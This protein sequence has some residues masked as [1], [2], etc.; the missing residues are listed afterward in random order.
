MVCM[1]ARQ[2]NAALS[3]M[4]NKT[5]KY[6]ALGIAQPKRPTRDDGMGEAENVC[7]ASSTSNSAAHPDPDSMHVCSGSAQ[8]DPPDCEEKRDP[9]ARHPGPIT[10]PSLTRLPE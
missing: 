3:A 10:N 8:Q 9:R 2:V 7:C 1:E 5:D 6:D 4:R